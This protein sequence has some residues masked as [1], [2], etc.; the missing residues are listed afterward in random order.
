METDFIAVHFKINFELQSLSTD[1]TIMNV[2]LKYKRVKLYCTA[3]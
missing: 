1:S 2:K 3:R